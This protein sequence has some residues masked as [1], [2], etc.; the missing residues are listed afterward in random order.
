VAEKRDPIPYATPH[1]NPHSRYQ[2]LREFLRGAYWFVLLVALLLFSYKPFG[3]AVGD[4]L[5]S[6]FRN[7]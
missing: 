5:G 1:A 7:P 4:W 2:S 3:R 6:F